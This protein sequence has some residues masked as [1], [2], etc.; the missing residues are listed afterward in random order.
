MKISFDEHLRK[1]QREELYEAFDAVCLQ[2]LHMTSSE[3]RGVFLKFDDD[4]FEEFDMAFEEG[5]PDA[6]WYKMMHRVAALSV[7]YKQ[8]ELPPDAP[9]LDLYE[10]S[11]TIGIDLTQLEQKIE[12]EH[13][14]Q[15]H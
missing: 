1:K 5:G 13:S 8:R 10:H 7:I 3:V 11:L 4:M 2:K 14:R 6:M 12:R 15:D 9:W